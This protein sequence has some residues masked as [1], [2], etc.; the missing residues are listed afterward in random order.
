M[1]EDKQDNWTPFIFNT[2]KWMATIDTREEWEVVL[3]EYERVLYASSSHDEEWLLDHILEAS[4][5]SSDLPNFG[6]YQEHQGPRTLRD[7]FNENGMSPS[8][9]IGERPAPSGPATPAP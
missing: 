4:G 2:N 3:A 9:E 8:A 7:F 1:P 5:S 6:L